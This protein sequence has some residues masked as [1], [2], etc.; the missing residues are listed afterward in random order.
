LYIPGDQIYIFDC[1]PQFDL[2]KKGD[3]ILKFAIKVRNKERKSE[4]I[5]SREPIE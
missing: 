1:T 3:L 2:E 4:K 5:Y